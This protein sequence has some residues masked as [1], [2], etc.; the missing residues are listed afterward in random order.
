VW[1]LRGTRQQSAAQA[2][3]LRTCIVI[4]CEFYSEF[5]CEFEFY[6]FYKYLKF[7][8]F[9]RILKYH[10]IL[11]IKVALMSYNMKL[12]LEN[13]LDLV[14]SRRRQRC[15]LGIKHTVSAAAVILS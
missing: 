3:P 12:E 13:F 4:D 6:E 8:I 2:G 1:M 10:R 9:L 7:T 15:V 11:K 5:D 14:P